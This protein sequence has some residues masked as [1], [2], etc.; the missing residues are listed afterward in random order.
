MTYVHFSLRR[1]YSDQVIEYNLSP[2]I[3]GTPKVS[4]Q[5]YLFFHRTQ[6]KKCG[7]AAFGL[8]KYPGGDAISFRER[9]WRSSSS[10]E[11]KHLERFGSLSHRTVYGSGKDFVLVHQDG[12]HISRLGLFQSHISD[13]TGSLRLFGSIYNNPR[14]ITNLVRPITLNVAQTIFFA[15]APDFIVEFNRIQHCLICCGR[16]CSDMIE[17]GNCLKVYFK[18]CQRRFNLTDSILFHIKQTRPNR[19]AKP[20]MK[21]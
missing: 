10:R 12:S 13:C 5:R 2:C 6:T 16:M 21:A 4:N 17:V 20:F 9:I 19:Y 11:Y 8:K 7:F 18:R 14:Q 15:F 1:N 3:A